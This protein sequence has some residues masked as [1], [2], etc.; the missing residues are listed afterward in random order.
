MIKIIINNEEEYIVLSLK[1]MKDE[2]R[3]ID[4]H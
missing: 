1:D 4:E 3:P 2:S